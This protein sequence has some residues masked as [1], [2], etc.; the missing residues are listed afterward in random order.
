MNYFAIGYLVFGLAGRCFTIHANYVNKSASTAEF[1][2][3][4]CGVL[5]YICEIIH[6]IVDDVPSHVY[7]GVLTFVQNAVILFQGYWYR[8]V[9]S[10]DEIRVQSES[11]VLPPRSTKFL[12]LA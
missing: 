4:V 10:L 8:R 3:Y 5:S 7:M 12:K 1:R 2:F 9:R 6:G 11:V